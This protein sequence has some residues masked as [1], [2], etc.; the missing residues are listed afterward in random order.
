[1]RGGG[2][3]AYLYSSSPLSCIRLCR[4]YRYGFV[5]LEEPFYTVYHFGGTRSRSS[6]FLGYNGQLLTSPGALNMLYVD[7][8]E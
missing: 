1:M 2:V 4:L 6:M 3:R 7:G 8:M 5:K